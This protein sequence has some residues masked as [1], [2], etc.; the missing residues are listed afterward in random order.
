MGGEGLGAFSELELTLML[1]SDCGHG[2]SRILNVIFL[3]FMVIL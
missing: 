1:P 2:D 3:L